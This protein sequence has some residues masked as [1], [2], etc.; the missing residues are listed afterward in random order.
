MKRKGPIAFRLDQE[1]LAWLRRVSAETGV[2]QVSIVDRGT[3]KELQRIDRQ[4]RDP[5]ARAGVEPG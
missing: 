1:L 5:R 4:N 2:S 3:R